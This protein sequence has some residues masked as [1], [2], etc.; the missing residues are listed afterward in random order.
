MG[1]P[2]LQNQE[3]LPALQRAMAS[4]SSATGSV[5]RASSR[6]GLATAVWPLA[7]ALL[8]RRRRG[9]HYLR[10]RDGSARE[11]IFDRLGIDMRIRDLDHDFVRG[12][13][14]REMQRPGLTILLCDGPDKVAEVK[15]FAPFMKPGDLIMAHDYAPRRRQ[16]DPRFAIVLVV[17]RDHRRPGRRHHPVVRARAGAA[18]GV[19]TGGVDVRGQA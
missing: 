10:S 2:M 6:S 14:A 9:V 16:F 11:P 12:E 17:V 13:I 1:L 8:R 5:W 4:S 15:T 3:T 19:W 7:P 18:R